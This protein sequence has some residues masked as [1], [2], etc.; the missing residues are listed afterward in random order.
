MKDFETK[1]YTQ[2]GAQMGRG[3]GLPFDTTSKL[4]LYRVPIDSGGY[5][6]GGAYWG[7]GAPLYCAEDEDGE[8][9]YF[10]ASDRDAA[11]LRFPNATFYR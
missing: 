9:M 11:K 10:R 4:R 8:V 6:K 1:G 5:D 3:G 7:L 2:Y